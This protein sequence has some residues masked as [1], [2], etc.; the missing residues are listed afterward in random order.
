MDKPFSL[1]Y[2]SPRKIMRF[3]ADNPVDWK[4]DDRDVADTLGN[5]KTITPGM[6]LFFDLLQKRGELFTQREYVLFANH[7]WN[8]WLNGFSAEE[9]RAILIRTGVNFY[10]SAIDSLHV[11]G[12]LVESGKFEMCLID[13]LMDAVSKVDLTLYPNNGLLPIKV[14]LFAPTERSKKWRKQKAKFRGIDSEC[15]EIPLDMDS[16]KRPGNKRW[17]GIKDLKPIFDKLNPPSQP[18]PNLFLQEGKSKCGPMS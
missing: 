17:Y 10:P 9:R 18:P 7:Y 3:L 11:W 5:K 14:A 6:A 13:P 15:V 4:Y 16:P 8:E 2:I 1:I 12:L